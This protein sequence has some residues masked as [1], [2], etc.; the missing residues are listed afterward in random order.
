M[1]SLLKT[2]LLRLCPTTSAF[3]NNTCS[4]IS[5]YPIDDKLY[6]LTEEQQLLR[7]SVFDLAQKELAPYAT[8]ID[9]E[10]G[11]ANL[12]EFWKLLGKQG[13]LGITVPEKYGGSERT[14]F[15]HCLVMEEL[16][17]ASG[18]IALSYGAHSNLCVN[19]IVRHGSDQQMLKYLPKLI[20]G[21]HIGALAMS[22]SSAGSDVISM[23]LTAEKRGDKFVLNGTKFWITNGPDADVV[24]VYAKT[25]PKKS[26]MELRLLLSKGIFL[27]SNCE[28]RKCA[29]PLGLMQAACDVAFNYAHQREAFGTKSLISS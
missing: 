15:D 16:S 14:Y 13:L 11:F 17:R 19:Q 25:N 18:S 5:T 29:R 28:V 8:E 27:D 10:N 6:G 12:R 2:S 21:S 4:S 24:I 20:D 23:R 9:R 1:N 22:E 7:Q 26:S 3:L